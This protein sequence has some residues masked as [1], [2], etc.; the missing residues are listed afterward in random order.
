MTSE[1]NTALTRGQYGPRIIL[2]IGVLAFLV[3]VYAATNLLSAP[4]N[5]WQPIDVAEAISGFVGFLYL[6]WV[7]SSS[8]QPLARDR[9]RITP[10]P[11]LPKFFARALLLG[12]LLGGAVAYWQ[13]TAMGWSAGGAAALALAIMV[14]SGGIILI[15][16]RLAGR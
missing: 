9:S 5:T 13:G 7:G 2:G 16:L 14:L 15:V 3:S 10:A 1:D 8:K 12:L 11:K 4:I 6:T